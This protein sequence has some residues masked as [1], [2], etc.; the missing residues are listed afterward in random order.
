MSMQELTAVDVRPV[1]PKDRLAAILGAFDGLAAGD[2]V[3]LIVDHDPRCMYYT[4]NA[5]H[6]EGSFSFE[7]LEEGPEVWRVQVGKPGMRSGGD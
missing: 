7:Y 2:R 1:A 3:D 6:G 5:M 4:L